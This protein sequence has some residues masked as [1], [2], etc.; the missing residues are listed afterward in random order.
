MSNYYLFQGFEMLTIL[1]VI[2]LTATHTCFLMFWTSLWYF[3]FSSSF[4][5]AISVIFKY[6]SYMYNKHMSVQTHAQI[7][8][9]C[10]MHVWYIVLVLETRTIP[11][12]STGE[13]FR[14]TILT[15]RSLN[16]ILLFIFYLLIKRFLLFL[17]PLFV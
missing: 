11:Y 6:S 13:H 5:R 17:F 4:T 8:P 10:L 9:F 14:M 15:I 16:K 7:V 1:H 3:S 2:P 12:K